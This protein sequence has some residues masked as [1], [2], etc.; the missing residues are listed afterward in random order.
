MPTFLAVGLIFLISSTC[1]GSGSASDT[2][3]TL[4]PD[5]PMLLT[6]LADTGSV[7]AV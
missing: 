5:L 4:V 3:V 2:P 6:S 7:T 1:G